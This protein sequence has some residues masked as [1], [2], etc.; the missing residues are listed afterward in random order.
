[1]AESLR[2]MTTNCDSVI[3]RSVL[4]SE[5]RRSAPGNDGVRR[6]ANQLGG[7]GGI[8]LGAALRE[9]VL[10][11]QALLFDVAKPTHPVAQ[12]FERWPRLIGK[13]AD[14]TNLRAPLGIGS[15][16]RRDDRAAKERNELAAS[17]VEHRVS[18]RLAPPAS[19]P[20]PQSAAERPPSPWGRPELF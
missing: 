19:L 20:H 5:A 4:S 2:R 16:R 11:V 6:Q 8:A 7:K 10:E 17:H 9:A 18:S 14:A 12:P 15:E 13:N 3:V 1:T